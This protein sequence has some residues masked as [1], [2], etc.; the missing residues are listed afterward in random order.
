MN[1]RAQDTWASLK[2]IKHAVIP[3]IASF[4]SDSATKHLTNNVH[5]AKNQKSKEPVLDTSSN[6]IAE[7]QLEQQARN[8]DLACPGL[9]RA[10]TYAKHAPCIRQDNAHAIMPADNSLH[11]WLGLHPGFDLSI[12][13][14][15]FPFFH[16]TPVQKGYPLILAGYE[17][18]L[19][20]FLAAK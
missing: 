1:T 16:L 20:G 5:L 14:P 4:G 18:I 3:L 6:S 11:L 15:W 17:R 8:N 9:V 19:F 12:G 13:E 10:H 7:R 2:N